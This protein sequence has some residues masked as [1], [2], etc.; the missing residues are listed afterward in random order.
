MGQYRT[1][2]STVW[3]S[4]MV[5]VLMC[6]SKHLNQ[7]NLIILF[8]RSLKSMSVWESTVVLYIWPHFLCFGRTHSK[9]IVSYWFK[10][11]SKISLNLLSSVLLCTQCTN[12]VSQENVKHSRLYSLICVHRQDFVAFLFSTVRG[13]RNKIKKFEIVTKWLSTHIQQ[14]IKFGFDLHLQTHSTHT[15]FFMF[16]CSLF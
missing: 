10:A 3:G 1:C 4:N 14:A 11:P 13:I 15:L 16:M 9:T 2:Q 5:F 8:P 12:P 7:S 6:V